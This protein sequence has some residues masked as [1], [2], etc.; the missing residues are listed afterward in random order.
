MRFYAHDLVC[1]DNSTNDD[2]IGKL[3]VNSNNYLYIH[4][5]KDKR[6]CY[7]KGAWIQN[8]LLHHFVCRTA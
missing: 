3:S 6:L 5:V 1:Y 8:L 2:D 7:T 4:Y